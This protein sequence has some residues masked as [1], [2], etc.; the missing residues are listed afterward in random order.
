[1]KRPTMEQWRLFL[2][3]KQLRSFAKVAEVLNTDP[4]YVGKAVA[5]LEAYLGE[6]LFIRTRPKLTTTWLAEQIAPKISAAISELDRILCAEKPGNESNP[7][8]IGVPLSFAKIFL[9]WVSAFQEI[10]PDAIFEVVPYD[11]LT[12]CDIGRH[13]LVVA[14]RSLPMERVYAQPMGKN[15]RILVASQEA[16]KT[17]AVEKPEDLLSIPLVSSRSRQIL[18]SENETVNMTIRSVIKVT[19]S[20][21]A[22]ECVLHR[23]CCAVGIPIWA[24]HPMIAEGLCVRILP[25]WSCDAEDV[26]LVRPRRQYRDNI[27]RKLAEYFLKRWRALEKI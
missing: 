19:D 7:Y 18:T 4:A 5:R 21:S 25:D 14:Q 15:R 23:Q 17:F 26:W 3:T 20:L 2:K 11:V 8:R 13:D 10:E 16:A 1:M 12:G 9:H 22:L 24:A 27:H 6:P